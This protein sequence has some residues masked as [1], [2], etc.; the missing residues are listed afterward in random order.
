MGAYY[1]TLRPAIPLKGYA[2]RGNY[3]STTHS[4]V[5]KTTEYTE[6]YL[7]GSGV[8]SYRSKRPHDAV[9]CPVYGETLINQH[10]SI[11][12]YFTS[13]ASAIRSLNDEASSL[14]TPSGSSGRGAYD[15][16]HLFY[17]V[18]RDPVVLS[19][20]WEETGYGRDSNGDPVTWIDSGVTQQGVATGDV[21]LPNGRLNDPTQR[22]VT[23]TSTLNTIQRLA[24][25]TVPDRISGSLGQ[26]LVDLAQLPKSVASLTRMA[27]EMPLLLKKWRQLSVGVRDA[28]DYCFRHPNKASRKAAR[29]A[30]SGYLEWMFVLTPYVE[31]IKTITAFLSNGARRLLVRET[32]T[33]N[34]KVSSMEFQNIPCTFTNSAGPGFTVVQSGTV[35]RSAHVAVGWM[36]KGATAS[37]ATFAS[38]A[39]DLNRAL[40]LWY[41]SLLW[42]LTPWTWLLDW[43]LHLGDSIDNAVSIHQSGYNP[44]YSWATVRDEWDVTYN[45]QPWISGMRLVKPL[46]GRLSAHTIARYPI[47]MDG[48]ILPSFSGLSG[49]QKAILGAL[50]FSHL[51]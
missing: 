29:T 22:A 47:Q 37:D 27:R 18:Q 13:Y 49:T 34:G 44:I 35:T 5:F 25:A 7:S 23:D 20:P 1:R 28:I 32:A 21:E 14:A 31:D 33:R 36:A 48:F 16:G 41:P 45:V 11:A 39:R 10:G 15:T 9:S 12:D 19:I 30:G 3:D 24:S 43:C 6:N 26:D 2:R 38:K 46:R 50:G 42:D 51:H 40:G 4:V 17:S 8:F